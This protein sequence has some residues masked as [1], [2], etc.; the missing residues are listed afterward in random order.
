MSSGDIN[1]LIEQMNILLKKLNSEYVDNGIVEVYSN[2]NDLLNKVNNDSFINGFNN[3]YNNLDNLV[4]SLDKLSN[5]S[6]FHIDDNDWRV[7]EVLIILEIF[8]ILLIIVII[9]LFMFYLKKKYQD[10]KEKKLIKG[11][12]LIE[13]DRL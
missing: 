2:F 3:F 8:L 11:H 1:D 5:E 9:V 12:L 4:I 6:T 10:H 7:N 13:N